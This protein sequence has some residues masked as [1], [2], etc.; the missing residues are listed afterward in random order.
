MPAVGLG[1]N[2]GALVKA[3]GLSYGEVAR[4]IGIED[5]QGI[6]ALVE[7]DSKKSKFAGPLSEFFKV[8][9]HR[10][11]AEDF[12][13][14]EPPGESVQPGPDVRGRAP[15]ISWIRAGEFADSPDNYRVGDA[16]DWIPIPKRAGPNT[17]CLRVEGDSMTSPHGKSYP[18]GCI[19]FVD[20]D[21]RSPANGKRVIAKLVGSSKVTF[22]VFVRDGDTV[23]LKPLNPQH[24]PMHDPFR[25]IGTIVGKWEDE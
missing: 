22:K 6:W 2:I 12:D 17:Y 5:S 24:P 16:E 15:L 4:G 18:D 23:F 20:P 14:N 9:L 8:P 25:V 1:R 10:L 7:R 13:V 3:R 11:M 21:Q 19:I